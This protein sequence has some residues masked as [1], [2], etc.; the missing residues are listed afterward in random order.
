MRKSVKHY[1]IPIVMII[2]HLQW[3][4]DE[5]QSFKITSDDARVEYII[6]GYIKE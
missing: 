4:T 6:Y 5:K 2:Y 3:I 1:V